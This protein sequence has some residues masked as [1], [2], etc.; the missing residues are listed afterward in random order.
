MYI[1][2]NVEVFNALVDD[3]VRHAVKAAKVRGSVK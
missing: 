3:L 2:A 1:N